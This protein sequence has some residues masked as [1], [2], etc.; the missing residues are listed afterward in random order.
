MA[1]ISWE[2][3]NKG[4]SEEESLVDSLGVFDDS[5]WAVPKLACIEDKVG[6]VIGYLFTDF[7]FIYLV[8]VLALVPVDCYLVS[9]I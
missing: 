8:G 2:Y 4:E 3:E 6:G 9:Y 5:Y 7:F 1:E